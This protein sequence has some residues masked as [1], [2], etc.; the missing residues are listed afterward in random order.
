V[1]PRAL[2]GPGTGP[3]VAGPPPAGRLACCQ[4]LKTEALRQAVAELGLEAVLLGIRRDEHGVRAKERTFS[5]RTATQ[6][7]GLG[8]GMA[9][10]SA[11]RRCPGVP[12]A[13]AAGR[14]AH[15][16]RIWPPQSH[17]SPYDHGGT[18]RRVAPAWAFLKS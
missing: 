18:T 2:Q 1:R 6:A 8:Q 15:M 10:P 11:L 13:W 4:A 16:T 12:V 17:L 7:V 5:P 9:A 14:L 3:A